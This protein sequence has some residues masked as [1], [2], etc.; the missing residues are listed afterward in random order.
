LAALV[1][2]LV[3]PII[4]LVSILPFPLLFLLSDF[5][6]FVL[7]YVIGYR[8]KI[9]V[10]NLRNAFPDKTDKEINRICKNFFHY[11]CDLV[12]ETLKMLTISKEGILKHCR[13]DPASKALLEKL[14]D[15][16]KSFILVMGHLGN[17]EWSGHPFSLLLKHKLYVLYHPIGNK[18][19]DRLMYHIRTRNGTK[20]IPMSQAYK[21][22]LLHKNELTS[23][24]FIA[25][26]TPQPQNGYWTTF[27]N[28]DTPIFKGTEII[29]KKMNRAVVYA[30]VKRVK[31][32]YYD[33]YATLL[34]DNP[35]SLPDG[36]LS[37][38][39]TRKLEQDII[40]QPETWLWS[41]RRWKHKRPVN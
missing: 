29:A 39:H 6:Y 22:M 32:G 16:Q 5:L 3:I 34:T 35:A 9:V 14:A 36:Q 12:L 2:Y 15:E 26:Q 1:Y 38:M 25:D 33:M 4:Y 41:H 23:T 27:L 37:E 8:K 19:F 30:S 13:F 40:A 18:Y 28:Q 7:Y 20:L 21:E 17:W 10:Q 24:A 31:R 11:L